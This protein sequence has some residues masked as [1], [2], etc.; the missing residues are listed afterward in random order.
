MLCREFQQECRR[1]GI[2]T[3]W[4]GGGLGWGRSELGRVGGPLSVKCLEGTGP[5]SPLPADTSGV[6]HT[7]AGRGK[8]TNKQKQQQQKKSPLV[9][10]HPIAVLPFIIKIWF[11]FPIFVISPRHFSHHHAKRFCN[12]VSKQII[13]PLLLC[14]TQ[15]CSSSSS[16][17]I[18]IIITHTR[19]P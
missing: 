2:K 19:W 17:I 3:V 4:W 10:A 5:G 6:K 13:I 15:P 8:Q 11:K 1:R 16:F 9:D 7:N 12:F 14:L 18:I